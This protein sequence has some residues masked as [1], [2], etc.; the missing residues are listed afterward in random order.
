MS[1]ARFTP[2]GLTAPSPS[3]RRIGGDSESGAYE[4]A[5]RMPFRI[6]AG[7]PAQA[8]TEA[9]LGRRCGR[10]RRRTG[11]ASAWGRRTTGRSEAAVAG[12]PSESVIKVHAP[13]V[14]ARRAVAQPWRASGCV[15][16]QSR[17]PSIAFRRNDPPT[18]S[19][20]V[21]CRPRLRNQVQLRSERRMA[22]FRE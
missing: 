17:A 7:R 10:A 14:K 5:A 19:S 18:I 4:A 3:S 20:P 8:S 12:W 9:L 11:Q 6:P 22:R 1:S 16:L 21:R 13:R 2:N 15:G